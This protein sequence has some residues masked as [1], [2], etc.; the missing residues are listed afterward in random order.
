Y[1]C[2]WHK[3]GA[4]HSLVT[5][6]TI[7]LYHMRLPPLAE[8]GKIREGIVYLALAALGL[9]LF[10]PAISYRY[11]HFDDYALIVKDA[12]YISDVRNLGKIFSSDVFRAGTI[13][14]RPG[15][16]VSFMLDAILGGT[17]PWAH[18]LTN[19]IVHIL[20]GL[21]LFSLF[22]MNGSGRLRSFLIC[23]FFLWHPLQT[24]AVAWIPGRNDSLMGL[25]IALSL[26]G[27]IRF[28]RDGRPG[29]L[30][31]HLGS[32]GCALFTKE[33]AA[34]FPLAAGVYVWWRWRERDYRRASLLA[35]WTAVGLIWLLMRNR[36][37]VAN[38][39]AP[40]IVF[41]TLTENILGFAG[42]I[43]KVLFPLRMT[44]LPVPRSA[45]LIPGVA[46]LAIFAVAFWKNGIRDR[47]LFTTGLVMAV[48]FMLPHLM[49][50]TPYPNYLEHR[51]YVPLLGI[52]I[53]LSRLDTR[54]I[55]NNYRQAAALG[56]AAVIGLFG[57]RTASRLPVFY[58]SFPILYEAVETAPGIALPYSLL[59]GV[60]IHR[61]EY[62]IAEI[63]LRK[64]QRMEP[65]NKDI[66]HNLGIVYESTGR[67]QQAEAA[68]R[69]GL[70][71]E[72][73]S[74]GLRYNL[75]FLY[76]QMGQP[77]PASRQYQLALLSNPDNVQ[78]W[79][80]LGMI[81]HQ[82]RQLDSAEL[83]YHHALKVEPDLP[84][85]NFNLG[86]LWQ[87]RGDSARARG[88]FNRALRYAPSMVS[89]LPK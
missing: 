31:L 84:Q 77:G 7:L 33:A 69:Q 2:I 68:F 36:A 54:K 49:R 10:L 70:A 82:S 79:L 65:G 46:A 13:A 89:L 86:V 61:E 73:R 11:T 76:Q 35:G 51:M 71:I 74:S 19:V 5:R 50:G 47:R 8:I 25:W 45:D 48:S 52:A 21:L 81:F 87:Q 42:Y 15:L 59:S 44:V 3:H 27:L 37:L 72:P 17:R 88:Y 4:T 64:T 58:D 1:H 29:W 41:N 12:G 6:A 30:M 14:Y 23:L 16:N 34:V 43:G 60:Y 66:Y 39:D 75:G 20:T 78:S 32:W 28:M 57:I 55:A 18:H 62:D 53:M 40:Q 85:A 24:Q 26:F 56:A 80:N 83:C 9:A 67:F 38:P 22:R 63:Y